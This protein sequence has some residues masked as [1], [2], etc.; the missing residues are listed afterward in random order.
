MTDDGAGI[1][2]DEVRLAIQDLVKEGLRK[3][4]LEYTGEFRNGQPVYR[5][6]DLGLAWLAREEGRLS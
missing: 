5:I 4:H 2:A 1:E 3:G 6:T